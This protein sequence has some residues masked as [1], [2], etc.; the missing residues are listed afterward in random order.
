MPSLLAERRAP[1]HLHEALAALD[2]FGDALPLK[3]RAELLERSFALRSGRDAPG[4]FWRIDL[5]ALDYSTLR[6]ARAPAAKIH[7]KVVRGA[8]ACDL[9]T[10]SQERGDL[11]E[12]AMGQ[13]AK[14][15]QRKFA[16]LAA[17]LCNTGAFIYVPEG[18]CLD[19][20]IEVTYEATSAGLFPWTIVLAERGSQ[21]TLIERLAGE[22]SAFVCS[23]A[24]LICGESSRVEY[25]SAQ[26]LDEQGTHLWTCA[27]LPYADAAVSM[28]LAEIGGLISAGT[29]EI[30]IE[31]RGT[32]A[33]INGL[34]FPTGDQHVDFVSTVDHK[35]GES[36]SQTTV[37]SAATGAGQARYLG[38]IRIAPLAQATDARLRDDALLLSRKAHIDSVPA[39]EIAANDVKAY[40]GA[41]VGALDENQIFY[42]GSRGIERAEAERM[43]AVGFFEPVIERF[44]SAVRGE[45]RAA[46][47]AKISP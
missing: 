22:R 46:M 27:G 6:P 26:A 21:C 16:A 37:K 32:Q 28:N 42:M 15:E 17:A 39:L 18:V 7:A 24:E 9:R 11:L 36:Q 38:N 3:R 25:A 13:A 12:R 5:D 14:P 47:E 2:S 8:F 40:H 33:E 34:F 44:P 10:A 19:E 31:R 29:A 4:R 35:A 43:I 45:L 41:T 30:A 23:I 20:P 1:E